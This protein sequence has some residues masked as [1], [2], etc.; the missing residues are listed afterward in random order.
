MNKSDLLALVSS[1]RGQ[2]SDI[3][4]RTDINSD[5]IAALKSLQIKVVEQESYIKTI[6]EKDQK[7]LNHFAELYSRLNFSLRNFSPS[8]SLVVANKKEVAKK[9]ESKKVKVTKVIKEEEQKKETKKSRKRLIKWLVGLGLTAIILI[10]IHSCMHNANNKN[11]EAPTPSS[12]PAYETTIPDNAIYFDI[13]DQDSLL[14]YATYIQSQLPEDSEYTLED[15]IYALR[16]AN[17]EDLADAGVFKDRDEIYQSTKVIGGI[18]QEIGVDLLVTQDA[19][20]DIFVSEDELKDI[21]M[22]VTDNNLSVDAFSECMTEKGY[23]IYLLCQTCSDIINGRNNNDELA[24]YY[25]K[26]NN[27]VPL[28]TLPVSKTTIDASE[29]QRYLDSIPD[30]KLTLDNFRNCLDGNEY[31]LSLIHELCRQKS[32]EISANDLVYYAKVFNEIIARKLVTFSV[33]EESPVSTYYTLIGLYNANFKKINELT[34]GNG[35]GP[36]YGDGTRIDG[37]YGCICVEELTNYLTIGNQENIFFTDIIDQNL[38][39]DA[40]GRN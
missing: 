17:Y 9:S 13:N 31:N 39:P 4:K 6:D 15:I 36:I 37:T 8:T 24:F 34:S 2:I 38:T 22:C 35:W 25:A 28:N 14:N 11:N 10:I 3:L 20:T 19:D 23:D 7:Q 33:T 40:P 32:N 21:I 16:L 30:N 26:V 5:Q 29:F 12:T 1:C 27:V 18:S